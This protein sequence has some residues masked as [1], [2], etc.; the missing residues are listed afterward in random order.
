MVD[1]A[2]L[3]TPGLEMLLGRK[4]RDGVDVEEG[5]RKEEMNRRRSDVPGVA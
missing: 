5:W 3:P 4:G 1:R 2:L